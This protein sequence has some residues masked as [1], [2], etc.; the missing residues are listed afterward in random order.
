VWGTHHQHP[1]PESKQPHNSTSKSK[2]KHPPTGNNQT[3]VKTP[4]LLEASERVG[5]PKSME[6]GRLE[7]SFEAMLEWG[8][9]KLF[10]AQE[11]VAGEEEGA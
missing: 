8:V 7:P 11:G 10:H 2:S 9:G 5:H 1:K 6:T 4:N 3:K